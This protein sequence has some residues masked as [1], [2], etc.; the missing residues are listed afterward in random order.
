[1]TSLRLGPDYPFSRV[2]LRLRP[3]PSL[4]A[5]VKPGAGSTAGVVGPLRPPTPTTP[6]EAPFPHVRL[7]WQGTLGVKRHGRSSLT[8]ATNDTMEATHATAHVVLFDTARTIPSEQ[9]SDH[10]MKDM[11]LLHRRTRARRVNPHSDELLE[12]VPGKPLAAN[13]WSQP[14]Q[15]AH[16][17]ITTLLQFGDVHHA[18]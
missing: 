11:Y 6:C 14:L 7:Y 5:E 1:M 9:G 2:V 18:Y 4:C 16:T 8:D 10:S 3:G 13:T 12:E 17:V 15:D